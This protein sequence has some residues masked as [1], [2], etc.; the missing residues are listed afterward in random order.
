MSKEDD[1]R[2]YLFNHVRGVKKAYDWI[3]E[4]IP[5][6]AMDIPDIYL[7]D[8]SK[9][10]PEEFDAY[11]NFFYGERTNAVVEAFD[12]AWN[13]HQKNNPHH[14]QYW[15][16]IN[17]EEGTIGIPKIKCLDMPIEYIIEMICDWWSFSWV[18]NDLYEIFNWYESHKN[19]MQLSKKTREIVEDILDK[20]KDV[21]A[22]KG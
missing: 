18:K 21:L 10:T 5:D 19:S 20:I 1:Y 7:H 12:Y 15:V 14:W 8:N 11:A 9:F 17:D 16:L 13:K 22:E 6:Y 2:K 3:N 4:N